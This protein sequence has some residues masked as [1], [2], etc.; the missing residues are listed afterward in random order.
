[1]TND[2]RKME[3]EIGALSL[4]YYVLTAILGT[5]GIA[6]TFGADWTHGDPNFER[7]FDTC[8]YNLCLLRRVCGG[9]SRRRLIWV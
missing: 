7:D 9:A 1:M 5:V 3:N 2:K 6:Y 8:I 4:T